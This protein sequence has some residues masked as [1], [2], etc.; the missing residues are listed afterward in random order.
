MECLSWIL[1]SL[2]SIHNKFPV[3]GWSSSSILEAAT[4][5]R[6][7]D[8]QNQREFTSIA[9]SECLV[10]SCK[11]NS[12]SIIGRHFDCNIYILCVKNRVGGHVVLPCIDY[13]IEV[14][15]NSK[16]DLYM[17]GW[18]TSGTVN[19][20][21]V[22]PCKIVFLSC[23]SFRSPLFKVWETVFLYQLWKDVWCSLGILFFLRALPCLCNLPILHNL[24][25]NSR[26]SFY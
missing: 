23:L 25:I 16:Y 2:Y 7:W 5:S 14:L 4:G 12:F 3:I 18:D 26:Q 24:P 17:N 10:F 13:F 9:H 22:Y 19:A 15:S 6:C 21:Y 11:F 20:S 8:T 1:F